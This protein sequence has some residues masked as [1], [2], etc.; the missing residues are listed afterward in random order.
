[1]GANRRKWA[2]MGANGRKQARMNQGNSSADSV[3]GISGGFK[4]KN[5][6]DEGPMRCKGATDVK[7]GA[8]G[9][10]GGLGEGWIGIDYIKL[11]YKPRRSEGRRPLEFGAGRRNG[12]RTPATWAEKP[13][14]KMDKAC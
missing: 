5:A 3:Y 4:G 11:L 8:H 6:V 13:D 1:M 14:N 10:G 12:R 7:C 9:A 2:R